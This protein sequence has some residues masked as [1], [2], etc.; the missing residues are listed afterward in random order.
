MNLGQTTRWLGVAL[1]L[2]FA[3]PLPAEV[4]R[5]DDRMILD[6][7][8]FSRDEEMTVTGI[9][10]TASPSGVNFPYKLS[11][12]GEAALTGMFVNGRANQDEV[13]FSLLRPR[14]GADP[15]KFAKGDSLEV[16]GHW[17]D[18]RFCGTRKIVTFLPTTVRVIPP[19]TFHFADFADRTAVFD[20]TAVTGGKFSSMGELAALDGV[21]EWPE[22][23][24]NKEVIVRGIVR[25]TETGWRIE[26]PDWQLLRLDDQIGRLV[27]LGG[28][29]GC[30]NDH[31]TFEYRGQE[32][33][34]TSGNGPPLSFGC[35]DSGRSVRVTGLLLQQL[36]PS[37]KQI[38]LEVAPDLVPE[39]VVRGAKVEFL[40]KPSDT[41]Y[42]SRFVHA[43][44]IPF[45]DG[46]PVLI[47]QQ[48][49]HPGGLDSD[50][51]AV[52]FRM[53]NAPA[54]SAFLKSP[55]PEQINALDRRLAQTTDQPVLQLLYASMLAACNDARGR[56]FLAAAA[57]KPEAPTFPDALYCIGIFSSLP[58]PGSTLNPDTAWVDDLLPGFLAD[59]KT[60]KVISWI[61]HDFKPKYTVAEAMFS[62]SEIPKLLVRSGSAKVR[63]A[64]VGYALSKDPGSG[65]I[66]ELLCGD[67]KPMQV[68]LL[69]TLSGIHDLDKPD[70]TINPPSLPP[71]PDF[72]EW[73]FSM[74]YGPMA[75]CMRVLR[76]LLSQREP[77]VVHG[78]REFLDDWCV[79]AI[80]QEGMS[81]EIAAALRAELP[82]LDGNAAANIR[83]LLLLQHPD[84]VPELITIAQD[85][86]NLL[87]AE[88]L[89]ELLKRKDPRALPLYAS[90]LN[91][92][93]NG[94]FKDTYEIR[95]IFDGIANIGDDDALAEFIRVLAMPLGQAGKEFIDDNALHRLAAEHLINLTGESFGIDA[96]AWE[97]WFKS[98]KR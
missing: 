65:A 62:Y 79:C 49:Y 55:S 82:T 7:V 16:T 35:N 40:D 71:D 14:D 44:P 88:A 57:R 25:H 58:P 51:E 39:F 32:M 97:N 59:R 1:G 26:K 68:P 12:D 64:M 66:L 20:G 96:P 36:R 18:A 76:K 56:A 86:T 80:I 11:C 78:Y 83:F 92:A 46:V 61:D 38:S 50:T 91:R 5:E 43:D 22:F 70:R 10:A 63:E 33:Y 98:R 42:P 52:F 94:N 6:G 69:L 8:G 72:F 19:V 4:A 48:I 24:R 17:H 95:R 23:A 84:P 93:R 15:V 41:E 21:D 75:G 89:E 31:W 53:R 87:T 54:I 2:A 60:P 90:L 27:M 45:V 13:M 3:D 30:C 85:N 34:L 29:L 77:S 73:K 9:A 74:R 37:I 81:P 47:P 67:A 28:S